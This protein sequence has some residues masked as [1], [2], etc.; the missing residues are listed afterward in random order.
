MPLR[1]WRAPFWLLALGTG[2]KSF[3]DNPILG[4]QALNRRGLHAA[5]LKL[6]HRVAWSRRRRLASAVPAEW[7][8]QFDRDGFVEI[9]NFLPQP[10][11]YLLVSPF[12]PIDG[13]FLR[14]YRRF[15]SVVCLGCCDLRWQPPHCRFQ[16][17]APSFQRC[18]VNY[19]SVAGDAAIRL[20]VGLS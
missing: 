4:S 8:E 12:I 6:A 14:L 20:K 15:Q 13:Q 10:T 17:N 1:W 9:G 19:Q 3:A 18:P 16:Q 11:Y 7:R 2:A 5:R